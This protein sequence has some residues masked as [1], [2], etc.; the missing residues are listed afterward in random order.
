[1][2]DVSFISLAKVLP[3]VLAAAAPGFDGLALVKP[4]FEV[5]RERVGR[6]GVV[7]DAGRPAR[8]RSWPW[9]AAPRALGARCSASPPRACRG[10]RATARRFVW[11]AEAGRAGGV[12]GSRAA[13]ARGGWSREP[14]D[15]RT[16]LTHRRPRRR[17]RA[18]DAAPRGPRGGLRA[19]LRRRGDRQARARRRRRARARRRP[20]DD[21][22]DLC[23]VLGGDGTILHALRPTPA[24]ACRSSRST[25]ARSASWRRSSPTRSTRGFRPRFAGDFEVMR[26]RRWRRTPASERGDQRRLLPPQGRAS[27][28]PSWPT[29]STARRSAACAATAW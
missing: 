19:A 16:V 5:G 2:I 8:R 29:R 22:V 24:P 14:A 3:A 6:G 23:V 20:G 21:D 18:R 13:A 12:D 11:L 15:A 9:R 4:Q 1:M 28:W 7:R 17:G 10:R 26:C 27:G 25:S